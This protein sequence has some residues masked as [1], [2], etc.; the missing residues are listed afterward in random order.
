M[1]LLKLMS[2]CDLK[3]NN[4][5]RYMCQ[6]TKGVDSM[7]RDNGCSRCHRR[8]VGPM[9]TLRHVF[10]HIL[11]YEVNQLWSPDL[12]CVCKVGTNKCKI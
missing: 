1:S 5:T 7:L 11:L 6:Y 12:G 10:E 2:L 3:R 8:M 4:M 9:Y